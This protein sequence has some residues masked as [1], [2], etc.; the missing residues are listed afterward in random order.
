MPGAND[1]ISFAHNARTICIAF[2]AFASRYYYGNICDA[3][4]DT[5]FAYA[6]TESPSDG[7]IYD[8]F[9]NIEGVTH[10]IPSEIFIQKDRYDPI[11]DQLFSVVINAG[12]TSFAMASR[13][14]TTLNATNYLKKDKNYYAILADHWLT[15]Q[16]DIKRIFADMKQ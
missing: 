4:L 1:R 2:V 8:I 6:R 14:D 5:V 10:I 16:A 13:Y 7:R 3:D 11:L 12:I 15:I 9:S